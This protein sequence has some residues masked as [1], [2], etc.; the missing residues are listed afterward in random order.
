MAQG[1][2]CARIVCYVRCAFGDGVLFSCRR[3]FARDT[4]SVSMRAI[5]NA[6]TGG[7]VLYLDI[8]ILPNAKPRSGC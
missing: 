6:I 5:F 1:R 2:R 7:P 4:D 8:S 3:S